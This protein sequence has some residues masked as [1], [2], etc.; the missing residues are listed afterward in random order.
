MDTIDLKQ[1]FIVSSNVVFGALAKSLGN[2]TLKATAE[3]FGFNNK[4]EQKDLLLTKSQFPSLDSY[5]VGMIAQTGIGQS[6]I[7]STPMQM[8]L[9][10]VQLLMME[11]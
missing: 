6:S 3:N 11:L 9:V 10:A 7:L 1:A 4:L 8:A 2:E 5:E